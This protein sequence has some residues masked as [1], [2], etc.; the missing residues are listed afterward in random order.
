[1]DLSAG[2]VGT[3][4]IVLDPKERTDQIRVVDD[5][6][7]SLPFTVRGGTLQLFTAEPGVLH[8]YSAD[9]ERILSLTLPDVADVEWQLPT[10]AAQG[11]PRR[12]RLRAEP[13]DLWKWL[14]IAGLLCLLA[15]WFL[16]GRQRR[17]RHIVVS[18]KAAVQREPELAAK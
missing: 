12:S 7:L 6:G 9:R 2:S 10:D 3:A 1:L 8:V 17:A 4:S 14:A 15:E 16:Y 18:H 13:V 5:T 11:L